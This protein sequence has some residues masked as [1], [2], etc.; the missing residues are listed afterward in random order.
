M[1]QQNMKEMFDN[2][3]VAKIYRIFS[4]GRIIG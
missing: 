4:I 2:E 1:L 3:N